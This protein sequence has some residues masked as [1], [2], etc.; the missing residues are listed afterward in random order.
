KVVAGAAVAGT[1]APGGVGITQAG[2]AGAGAGGA[3]GPA[4]PAGAAAR[5]PGG[6][7]GVGRAAVLPRFTANPATRALLVAGIT[8]LEEVAGRSAAE[9]L[10][11]HG[12][13]PKAVRILGEELRERG[14]DFRQ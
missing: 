9:L 5:P 1:G 10:A 4:A 3:A 13:G 8:N 2:A 6:P 14:L 12:V 11:L 7:A